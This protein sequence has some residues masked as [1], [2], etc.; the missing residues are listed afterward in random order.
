MSEKWK[1]E[2]H[3]SPGGWTAE[4]NTTADAGHDASASADAVE[5]GTAISGLFTVTGTL[6]QL[7]EGQ[8][9]AVLA[10]LRKR[11]LALYALLRGG[12]APE[13]L[14][15]L[16]PAAPEGLPG[17][18]ATASAAVACTCGR[19]GCAHAA[20]AERAVAARLAAEPL[21]QLAHAG[22]P[23]EALLAGVLG[24]WAEELAHDPSGPGRAAETA[25]RPQVRGGEGGAAVGE[26]I[27]EAAA[28]GAMH[29][30]GPG[31]GAIE[32][33]LAKPGKAPALPELTAL[34]PGVPATAG[35]DLIRERV[36]ARMWQAVQKKKKKDSPATK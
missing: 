10:Q 31:F 7:S 9:E 17:A 1:I 29:Q 11:P 3:M 27:A 8:R 4:V 6:P 26:W 36:A 23:R 30:P 20:A 28:D 19:T 21:L 13:E 35:L 33:H 34:M 15:G 12:P 22:L 32:V 14:A 24:T 2:L 16:L 5:N 18:A 25:G